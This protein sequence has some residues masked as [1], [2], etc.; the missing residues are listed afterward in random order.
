MKS[1]ENNGESF[2]VGTMELAEVKE[3]I[4]AE[5]TKQAPSLTPAPAPSP[6][7]AQ[8]PP[9]YLK[10]CTDESEC[11]QD[12]LAGPDN[13]DDPFWTGAISDIDL[14]PTLQCT[15]TNYNHVK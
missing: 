11:C 12:L 13:G 4:H 1:E 5:M 3:I 14:R 10:L 2:V 6:A 8:V 15:H 9:I 7:P